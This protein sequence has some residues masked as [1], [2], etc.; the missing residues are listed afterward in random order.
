MHKIDLD[1]WPRRRHFDLFNSFDHPHF[2][3]CA[4]LDVSHFLRYV[5]KEDHGFTPALVYLL[6]RTANEIAG[7]R[8][9]IRDGQVIEHQ[10]VHPS[11][12]VLTAGDLFSFC[13]V[14][15]TAT[16][17]DFAAR[18]QEQI[19]SVQ[20]NLLLAGEPGRDDLLFMT[21]IPWISFTSFSHPMDLKPADSVPRFA[22]GKYVEEGGRYLMPLDVQ[23]H[24]A[25][26]D[27]VHVGRFYNLL[28]NTLDRPES[29]MA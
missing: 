11:F 19:S 13:T 16:F 27:G 28:Q 14:T 2:S 26:M 24:H 12:T 10:E 15:Y 17:G 20:Q 22:W 25:L 5:K 21:A 18:C 8:Q 6:A 4:R 1:N 9:R 7:F 29:A 3:V 23:V